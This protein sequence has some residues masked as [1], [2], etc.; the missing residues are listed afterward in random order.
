MRAKCFGKGLEI[1]V[2]VPTLRDEDE[3]G[4]IK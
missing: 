2:A 3:S 1:L 4:H